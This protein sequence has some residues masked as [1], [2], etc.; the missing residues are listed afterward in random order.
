MGVRVQV[1]RVSQRLILRVMLTRK[2]PSLDAV[3]KGLVTE[4]NSG[5]V[6]DY[7][8]VPSGYPLSAITVERHGPLCF[9]YDA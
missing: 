1:R 9:Q 4:A 3:I 7:A 8:A 5:V 2:T 6:F